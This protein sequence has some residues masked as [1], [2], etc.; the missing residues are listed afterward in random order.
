MSHLAVVLKRR[1][2]LLD[3][4]SEKKPT[5][6]L[7]PYKPFSVLILTPGSLSSLNS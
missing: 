1:A 4:S 6:P 7:K 3:I 2:R 5:R